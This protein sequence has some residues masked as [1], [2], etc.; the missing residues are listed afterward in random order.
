[1]ALSDYVAV[2]LVVAACDV[3]YHAIAYD[4]WGTVYGL[5]FAAVAAVTYITVITFRNG[6]GLASLIKRGRGVLD[7]ELLWAATLAADL[8]ILFLLGQGGDLSRGITVLALVSGALL[9]PPLH[10]AQGRLVRHAVTRYGVRARNMVLVGREADVM[11][12]LAN[13][14]PEAKGFLAMG[15]VYLPDERHGGHRMWLAETPR[16]ED[17]TLPAALTSVRGLAVDD[18]VLVLPLG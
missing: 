16:V 6:Y 13:A 1:M 9:L 11:R 12:Y 8:V 3:L 10:K 18:A 5:R 2:F 17:V 4:R 14:R 15:A 7:W